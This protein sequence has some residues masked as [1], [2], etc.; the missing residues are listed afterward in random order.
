MANIKS[1]QKRIKVIAKKT[2][3]NKIIKSQLKT[4]I[5]RFEDALANG[6]FED[7]QARLKVVEKKLHQAAAKNVIHKS[8]ASRKVSR[9]AKRVNQA[10]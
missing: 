1:A 5:K 6:N 3:R 10:V 2:A 7:A 8:K 9:F 4:A